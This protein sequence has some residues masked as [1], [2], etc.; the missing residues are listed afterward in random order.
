M[1]RST[2]TSAPGVLTSNTRSFRSQPAIAAKHVASATIPAAQRVAKLNRMVMSSP[3]KVFEQIGGAK[4]PRRT[5]HADWCVTRPKMAV[6]ISSKRKA[7]VVP[8][9]LR[10]NMTDAY[11]AFQPENAGEMRLSCGRWAFTSHMLVAAR[12]AAGRFD[13]RHGIVR[14]IEVRRHVLHVVVIVEIFHQL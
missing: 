8:T 13:G 4:S 2:F 9:C 11:V 3:E 5:R 6:T 10:A 12:S 7:N 14:N 1:L